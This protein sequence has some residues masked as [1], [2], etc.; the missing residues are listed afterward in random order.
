MLTAVFRVNSG[1]KP[2]ENTRVGDDLVRR[3]RQLGGTVAGQDTP[4]Q[5]RRLGGSPARLGFVSCH[6]SSSQL[7]FMKR[8]RSTRFPQH[9]QQKP[10]GGPY[11]IP[12][13]TR[14]QTTQ[15]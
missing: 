8:A 4:G 5:P 9:A 2:P 15:R 11:T 1:P 12:V 10:V 6:Q 3:L 13:M 14:K 7:P